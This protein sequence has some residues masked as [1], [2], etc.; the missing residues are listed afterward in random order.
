MVNIKQQDVKDC[1]IAC[2]ASIGQHYGLHLPLSKIRQWAQTDLQ[3]TN[4]VGMLHAA[5][6]MGFH[7]KA[8]RGTREQLLQIPLPTIAHGVVDGR[9]THFVVICRLHDTYIIVMDPMD[10]EKRKMSWEA[11]EKFWTGIVVMLKPNEA[12]RAYND[13]IPLHVRLWTLIRTYR[14][15]LLMSW[16]AAILYT[17]LGLI[18]SL[19]IQ[20]M[21]DIIIPQKNMVM[22]QSDALSMAGILL[23]QCLLQ[24]YKAHHVLDTGHQLDQGIMRNYFAHIFTLP[25][26]F[27]DTFRVGEIMSRVSDAVKIR[28]F[29]NEVLLEILL[30]A[31]IVV[32]AFVVLFVWDARLAWYMSCMIPLHGLVYLLASRWNKRLERNMMEQTAHLENHLI[33]SLG[34]IRTLKLFLVTEFLKQKT[35]QLLEKFLGTV[36]K[37]N[38]L[39][40]YS[41]L[42]IQVIR[43]FFTLLLLWKGGEL[44]IQQRLSMGE[45]FALFALYG[46]FSGPL[47][48]LIQANKAYQ[49]AKIASERFFDVMDM[50]PDDSGPQN[51]Q[52]LKTS[53]SLQRVG[54]QYGFRKQILNNLSLQI[55]AGEFTGI[56]GAS[57]SGKSTIFHLIQKIYTPKTGLITW[58][59]EAIHR[60]STARLREK[61]ACVPQDI[62]LFN[63]SISANIA[64]GEQKP[65]LARIKKI[66]ASIGLDSMVEQ[67]EHGYETMLGEN[68]VAISGGQKQRIAIARALYRNPEIILLDEATSSLDDAAEKQVLNA[69]Q[70]Q[71]HTV[72]MISHR[73]QQFKQADR[74]HVIDAGTCVESGDHETLMRAGKLYFT[75]FTKQNAVLV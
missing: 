72:V 59:G 39:I 55:H 24:G 25:Q 13:Q 75:W 33:E 52:T 42:L 38:R 62:A 3:G 36:L 21:T 74:I 20:Q 57:G 67:F 63:A 12:F 16:V 18:M 8:L 61:I 11:F 56:V 17:V 29:V 44:V 71:V 45:L 28:H 2:L 22:L 65:D 4:L 23:L 35:N 49:A 30:N 58:D 41:D 27:F 51:P 26:R 64:L 14:F 73:M 54:F 69:I 10:G 48:Q 31:S 32:T 9:L 53:L 43:S 47:A 66:A 60:L 34:Q 7:A 5:N 46:Y 68:G 1:G 50:S 6:Q 70:E 40:A 37:S 19:F 15:R